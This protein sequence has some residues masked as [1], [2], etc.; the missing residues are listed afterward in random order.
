MFFFLFLYWVV[1]KDNSYDDNIFPISPKDVTWEQL[2]LSLIDRQIND[3]KKKVYN[4][5]LDSRWTS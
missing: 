5:S 2:Y 1:P 3:D 4:W